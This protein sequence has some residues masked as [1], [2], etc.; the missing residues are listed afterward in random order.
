MNSKLERLLKSTTQKNVTKQPKFITKNIN[1][2]KTE[3]AFI[4]IKYRKK[5]WFV[6]YKREKILYVLNAT[7]MHIFSVNCA[8]T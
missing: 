2:K 4:N 6:L 3:S 7:V 8:A 1:L 5:V